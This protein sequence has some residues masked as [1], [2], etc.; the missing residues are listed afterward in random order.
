MS[1]NLPRHCLKVLFALVTLVALVT[2]FNLQS[3]GSRV[4][5][6]LTNPV[7]F[8]ILHTNDFHGQLVP[9]GS[10]PGAA[11]M[12]K[13]IQ[14]I[15]TLKGPGNVLLLDA[16]DAMQGSLLSNVQKGFPVISVFN[17][18][19]YD[20]MTLGN[21]DY[22]WGQTIL[23]D[24]ITQA[25][26]PILSAN[27]VTDGPSG[28][29]PPEGVVPYIIKTVGTPESVKVAIVGVTTEETA[30][31]NAHQTVGL[32]FK[33]PAAAVL[34]YYD[35][36]DAAS[37]VIVVLS[38]IGFY[39]GGYGLGMNV[40]GDL[41]LAQK[42]ITAGKP[43]D[44]ILGGHSHTNLTGATKTGNTTIAQAH[45][46]GRRVG[47][48][49]VTVQPGGS[50]SVTW[51]NMTVGTSDPMDTGIQTLVTAFAADTAYL[52]L[53][54]QPVG[55]TQVPIERNY[56]DDSL[57]GS[58][59]CDAVYNAL[60]SDGSTLNDV[61]VVFNNPGGARKDLEYDTYPHVIT[62]GDMFSVL[63]FGNSLVTGEMTGAQIVELLNQSATLSKGALQI[64]GIR[65]QFYH[66]KDGLP[67]PQPWAW[68]AL[69]IQIRNKSTDAFEPIDLSQTYRV[70][71]NEF[72]APAGGDGFSA[73]KSMKNFTFWGDM[74]NTVLQWTSSAYTLATPFNGALDGRVT[75]DGD[76]DGGSIKPLTVLHHN[77]SHG[78]LVKGS[79]D[80]YTQL[81]TLI[82][83]ERQHNPART[84]LLSAGDQIQGDPMMYYFRTA[85]LG[86]GGDGSVLAPGLMFHPMMLAMNSMNYDAVTLG[87][88][89]FN[90]GS[91]ITKGIFK[92]AA[93]PILAA[94]LSDD[95]SYGLASIP[96]DDHAHT[97]LDGID[98]GII[99]ITNH[100]VPRFELPENIEG[101]TFTEP[102]AAAQTQSSA[103]RG[104]HDVLIALS[105]LGFNHMGGSETDESNDLQLA[106]TVSGLDAVIGG[107]THTNPDTGA[108]EY[109]YLPALLAGPGNTP[110]MVHQAYRYNN[111][112]GVVVL[113]LKA[114]AD[115][116]E[117]VSHAGRFIEVELT[118]PEDPELLAILTPYV[119][120][121]NTYT[122][123][124]IGKTTLPIDALP[125]FTQE[126]NAANLQA[127]AALV[128]LNSEGI[129]ADLFLGGAMTNRKIAGGATQYSPVDLK[130]SDL[131]TLMPYENAFV[132]LDM[133]GPQLKAVLERSYRNYYYYK[134][135]PGYGGYSY[136]T[137][138]MLDIS[139][140]GEIVYKE[141][142]P[143]AYD[144]SGDYVVSLKVNGQPVDFS[145]ASTYYK[146]A[147]V[148][149][150]ALGNV[151]F[152]NAGVSLWPL[153]QITHTT[154]F[155]ARDAVVDF[156]KAMGII[157][158]QVDQRL[159]FVTDWTPPVVTLEVPA[160]NVAVQDGITL[161]ASATDNIGVESV[162]F[163]IREPGGSEGKVIGPAFEAIPGTKNTV[164]GKWEAPL[165][166]LQLPDGDYVAFAKAEDACHN[167]GISDLVPFSIRNWA[168]VA[169][170][171]AS[172]NYKAGR[173]VPIKFSLRVVTAA[174]PNE[175][176]V[177]NEELTLKIFDANNMAT[178][179][180]VSTFGP[181]ATDY[182]IEPGT[183]YIT[184]FATLKTPK[185][186]KVEIYRTETNFLIGSFNFSTKK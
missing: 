105:H 43:V 168:A 27:L 120:Q 177:Y 182:R 184:N 170:L 109:K 132:V 146:V 58:F 101:L 147:T 17:A 110:V 10:N 96:V 51:N 26:F 7:T 80:G 74:L 158:P 186:Y 148:H 82:K 137:T 123:T 55:Y 1:R 2:A 143:A 103:L 50:V 178:P 121:L 20:A 157:S 35:E 174:D 152:N 95:G 59:L 164:T 166:T 159:K 13:A 63:P 4:E 14:D 185:T 100:N 172:E 133:N 72:L 141:I 171:P 6:A 57:M 61:D 94:N 165:E 183:L 93:F 11:R 8:T 176:F 107:H 129:P 119:N 46:N 18:I 115:G 114:N 19:G 111:T 12:A 145:D 91:S 179:L 122:N 104:S 108:G 24:R 140:N 76:D 118:T 134:Y 88:H 131:F 47:N 37:D 21:H 135:V 175:P 126:T 167:V 25:A 180:Q 87:E 144:P 41:T 66:Y 36:M 92:Q 79:F 15:R 49:Q 138:G 97:A 139:G 52:S 16:G 5:A 70:A 39:D 42:L 142:Y 68:G 56:Y 67:G 149:Y 33:D 128:K 163:Y 9:E 64:S 23:K 48:A 161:T 78:N 156:I 127:D 90:F 117:V 45:Y 155:Y 106:Q 75:R 153:S 86:Y 151:N 31:L 98:I 32:T 34:H 150:L 81:A 77:D 71:T 29:T 130:V 85:P 62:F 116:Y 54:S 73:F 65:H 136:Y 53:I 160:A 173:T 60:N 44:L 30:L 125:A 162:K 38:H 154:Q 22:D 69:D 28:W 99:G 83:Q 84:L 3:P 124:I 113:G 102:L 169:M 89:D 40:Y 181:K 112:L